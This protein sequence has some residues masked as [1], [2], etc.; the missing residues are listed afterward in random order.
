V[1]TS[2]DPIGSLHLWKEDP[3]QEKYRNATSATFLQLPALVAFLPNM[4]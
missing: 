2:A 4:I 1:H 3:F